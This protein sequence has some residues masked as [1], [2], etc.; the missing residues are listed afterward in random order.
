MFMAPGPHPG[1][2]ASPPSPSP[3]HR[4]S[5]P[6]ILTPFLLRPLLLPRPAAQV[7]PAVAAPLEQDQAAQPA[8][9]AAARAGPAV[10]APEI[11][12]VAR[13]HAADFRGVEQLRQ[14]LGLP[15]PPRPGV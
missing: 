15:Q 11:Q 12:L 4:H 5:L 2:A 6:L 9:G 14:V 7:V 13:V 10:V 1:S 3:F 8:V